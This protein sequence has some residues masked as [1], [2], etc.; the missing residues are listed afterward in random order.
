MACDL[1]KGYSLGCRDGIGGIKNVWFGQFDE[2]TLTTSAFEITDVEMGSASLHKYELKRGVGS[3]TETVT[4]S[5]ENGTVF[6]MHSLN[7]KWNKITKEFQNEIKLLAQQRLIIFVELNELNAAGKN[8][9]LCLG[10]ANGC[11]MSA[12]S[13]L[14]G[15]AL[16]DLNGYDL[17]F[18][19]QEPNPMCTVADY[20]TAPLDN[21]AFTKGSDVTS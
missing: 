13:T 7:L 14:S 6:W 8:I 15:V 20:T 19:S 11:E 21:S 5:S 3:V 18:E 2:I 17:T 9:V 16:G 1:V 4:A 10:S 12:G